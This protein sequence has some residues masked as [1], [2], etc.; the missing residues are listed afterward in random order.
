MQLIDVFRDWQKSWKKNIL[1]KSKRALESAMVHMSIVEFVI[2]SGHRL[3]AQWLK[4]WLFV[5]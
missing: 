1:Y 4:G 2:V 5:Y 3:Q